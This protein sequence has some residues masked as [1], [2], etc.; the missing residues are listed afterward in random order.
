MQLVKELKGRE[1]CF[2]WDEA[3]HLTEDGL[4]WLRALC[5][6]AVINLILVGDLRL[7][8]LVGK[9]DQLSSRIVKPSII[10]AV[11]KRDVSEIAKSQSITD[12]ENIDL[13]YSIARLAGGLRNVE[14]VL[15][16]AGLYAAPE[17]RA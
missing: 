10:A 15:R 17:C 4:E 2:I 5:E 14:N 8:S 11:G 7:Q 1:L 3:Q 12:P 13:L 6:A 9:I 16:L